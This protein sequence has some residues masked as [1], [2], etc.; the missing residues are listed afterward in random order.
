MIVAPN[1]WPD[2]TLEKQVGFP[3]ETNSEM[4]V[5]LRFGRSGP[6]LNPQIHRPTIQTFLRIRDRNKK[7][8]FPTSAPESLTFLPATQRKG[9]GE[10]E[11]LREG[12]GTIPGFHSGVSI[13]PRYVLYLSLAPWSSESGCFSFISYRRGGPGAGGSRTNR[14]DDKPKRV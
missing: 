13:C 10:H 1:G 12:R 8:S 7:S 6:H 9:R 2:V 4:I 11:P 5:S 3:V 14:S